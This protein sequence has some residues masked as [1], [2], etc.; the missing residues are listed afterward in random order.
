MQ[1][2][3]I[4]FSSLIPARQ[5]LRLLKSDFIILIVYEYFK[6]FQCPSGH[7]SLRLTLTQVAIKMKAIAYPTLLSLFIRLTCS[8]SSNLTRISE[9]ESCETRKS[10]VRI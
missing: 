6:Q 3:R 2:N 9:G 5:T 10:F 7:I 8:P 4:Q 1:L